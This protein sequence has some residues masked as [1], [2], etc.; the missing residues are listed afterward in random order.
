MDCFLVRLSV[1]QALLTAVCSRGLTSVH[2]HNTRG[3][4]WV[5]F[6]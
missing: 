4:L 3:V 6:R 2:P 5:F 1:L